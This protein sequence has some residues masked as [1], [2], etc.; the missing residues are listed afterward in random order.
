[1]LRDRIALRDYLRTYSRRAEAYAALKL[2][3]MDEA[4]GDWSYCTGGKSAF[5]RETNGLLDWV[6]CS[7]RADYSTCAGNYS[8]SPR[9]DTIS[10]LPTWLAG[11]TRPSFSMRSTSDAA[12]L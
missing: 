6:S 12:R 2:R 7:R 3:L 9:P 5:V 10:R 8:P 4:N 1:M 11:P